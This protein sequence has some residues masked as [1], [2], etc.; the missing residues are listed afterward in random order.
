MVD[1]SLFSRLVQA[2][3]PQ[4]RLILLGD[5][6]Q[7]ASVEAGSV[8]GDI[9]DTGTIHHYSSAVSNEYQWI[10]GEEIEK[11]RETSDRGMND[12][13]IQLTKNYRFSK[14]SGIHA[15]SQAVNTG[16][17]AQAM[18]L[19]QW[20]DFSDIRWR[21]IPR[22]DELPSSF[23]DWVMEH[24]TSYMDASDPLEAFALF[25]RS[26]ILSALREGPY[27]VYNLNIIVE[28]ILQKNGR[29]DHREKWYHGRPIMIT[30]ND[31]RLRLFNGDIGLNMT[32]HTKKTGTMVFF[33]SPDGSVRRF[34]SLRLHD[35]ETAYAMTV[36]KSQGSEFND[37]LFVLPDRDTPVLTRE[38]IYTAL[39][40]VKEKIQIWGKEDIFLTAVTRRTRRSSGL[41]DALWG[42]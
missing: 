10:T 12:C 4:S 11:D 18:E 14:Q 8:L 17:G 26:R 40:R 37:V 38:L 30:K 31:Y 36:H 29:I 6:D 20:G 35:H 24:Y 1:L 42:S 21:N 9:C 41:R 27:G 7:L 32:D 19:I 2:A 5:K 39:T 13:I 15:V 34:H 23:E 33:I 22:P 28:R 25:N 3:K 16:N